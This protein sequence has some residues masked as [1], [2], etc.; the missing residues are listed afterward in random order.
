MELQIL[1]VVVEVIEMVHL[2]FQE[3]VVQE[4]LY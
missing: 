2:M 4:L 3:M 1:E